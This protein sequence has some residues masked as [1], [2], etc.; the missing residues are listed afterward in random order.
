MASDFDDIFG[1]LKEDEQFSAT[2]PSDFDEASIFGDSAPTTSSSSIANKPQDVS[3]PATDICGDDAA[4]QPPPASTMAVA[5]ASTVAKASAAPSSAAPSS[6]KPLW[7]QI[8][9]T[10]QDDFLSWLDDG[11]APS[12][13]AAPDTDAVAMDDVNLDAPSVLDFTSLAQTSGEKTASAVTIPSALPIHV[14]T[15]AVYPDTQLGEGGGHTQIS[16]DDDD[17]GDDFLEK[18]VENAK[19]KAN[20]SSRESSN[21]SLHIKSQSSSLQRVPVLGKPLLSLAL[22]YDIRLLN[23]RDNISLLVQILKHCT[24]PTSRPES[25]RQRHVSQCGATL[26]TYVDSQ[27]CLTRSEPNTP[28]N[29][30]N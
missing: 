16:L 6:A 3:K 22:L 29:A 26:F 18:I 14:A 4:A 11:A 1:D 21:S 20:S 10:E 5:P 28:T 19:K 9:N 8:G 7:E 15:P 17:D 24:R 23:D 25:S 27:L 13:L 2:L 12:E 30:D